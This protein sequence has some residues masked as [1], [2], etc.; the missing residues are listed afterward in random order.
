M[1]TATTATPRSTGGGEQRAVLDT[2]RLSEVHRVEILPRTIRPAVSSPGLPRCPGDRGAWHVQEVAVP[3]LDTRGGT[4]HTSSSSP[5]GCASFLPRRVDPE[6]LRRGRPLAAAL[7]T[8]PGATHYKSKLVEPGPSS[9]TRGRLPRGPCRGWLR[10][11]WRRSTAA[12]CRC[13]PTRSCCMATIRP[14]SSMP[15]PSGPR[16]LPRAWR[17]PPDR[18]A[19]RTSRS[20]S[21][22]SRRQGSRR[23]TAATAELTSDEPLSST[24][25]P[26]GRP[27]TT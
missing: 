27:T 11:T 12:A 15:E 8:S 9:T 23:P 24:P 16:L 13:T 10:A 7:G 19:E 25:A 22:P 2:D 26:S 4:P 20:I 14:R 6:A 17:S 21:W 3:R 18:G 1:P 5:S